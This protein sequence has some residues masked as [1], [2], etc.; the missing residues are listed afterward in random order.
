MTC[1]IV[2]RYHHVRGKNSR[3]K[4][5]NLFS[6]RGHCKGEKCPAEVTVEVEDEPKNKASPCLFK[7]VIIGDK[8]HPSKEETMARQLTG[9]VREAMVKQVQKI[10]ALGVYERNLRYA[11]EDPLKEGNFT[12]VPSIDVLKTAKQQFNKKYRL[13]EDYFKELRMFGFFT[14][15]T[16]DESEDIKGYTQTNGE[17]PFT[18]HFFTEVQ[19][20]RFAKYCKTEKYST[21][22]IDATGSVVRQLKHQRDVFFYCMVFQDKNSPIMPLSG[23]LLC[24]HTAASITSYFNFFRGKIAIRSKV[25]RPAFV[26]IH[27]SATLINSVLASFNIENIHT[28]LRRCYSTLDRVYDTKKLCNMTFLRLC[29][30][31]AMKAFLRSL[32]K[33]NVSKETHHHLMSLFAILLNSTELE[34]AFVLYAQI[35]Y[36]YGDPYSDNSSDELASLLRKSDSSEFD[37]EPY[38]QESDVKD[39]KPMK[40]AFLDETDITM[41]PIIHQS[42]FN[43]KA[44]ANIQYL[45]QIIQKEELHK[46]P[47]NSLYSP[48]IIRLLHK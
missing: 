39:D 13:D 24:D 4:N 41:D 17:W 12:E 36:V 31:H 46:E 42:P 40:Q 20:D 22:H 35:V 23:A 44:C 6:G 3:K 9:D 34:G 1:A 29:C 38:L 19:L 33:L 25:A 32:F 28:Y 5:Y 14:R 48:K 11:N 18:V 27:F 7:V 26:V 16:D 8:N 43:V 15:C 2:F 37:I 21:L 10:G 47:S 45:R 30:A